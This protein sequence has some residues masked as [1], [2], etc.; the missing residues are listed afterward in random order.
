VHAQ[1]DG[2]ALLVDGEFRMG[3]V[4]AAMRVGEEALRTLGRPFHR[5]P[6]LLRRPDAH[7]LFG[8]DEDLGAEAAAD[9]RRDD[10]QLVLRRD[11]D[12]GRQHEARDMR[13][14]ARRVERER[15]RARVVIADRSAR[16]HGVGDEPVVDEI[17]LRH[18]PGAREG[19]IGRGLVAE[20]PLV[21]GVV[22]RDIVDDGRALGQRVGHADRRRQHVV[23]DDD[24]LARVF[25]LRVGVGDDDADMV[26]DIAHLALRQRR[27][28]ARLHR[29]AVLVVDHPAA[30]Q[31]ADLVGGEIVAG[32]HGQHAG[33][34]QRRRRVDSLD[35]GVRV[36][37]THEIGVGLSRDI[38]V[39]GVAALAG[40]IANIFLA[41]DG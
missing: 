6:D 7:R 37:R 29:R 18:M 40:D 38:D 4:I 22:A 12:E 11:A 10:A 9:V 39:V 19:G 41:T 30:D 33:L 20:M 5:P 17:E 13:V 2:L 15:V 28:A 25:R 1:A 16:L 27:M 32:Q 14:L 8:V 26:A 31:P 36:R 34:G 35:R 24:R 3:D 21:A 23:I